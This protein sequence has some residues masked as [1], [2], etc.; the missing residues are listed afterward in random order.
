MYRSKTLVV[1]WKDILL[2]YRTKEILSGTAVFSLLVIVVFNFAFDLRVESIVAVAP[3]ALW[4][5][6]AFAGVL[7]LGRSFVLERD[8]G[9]WE[10]LL[11][12]PIDRGSI[13]LGKLIGNVVFIGMVELVTLPIAT[14]LFNVPLVTPAIGLPIL[15]GTVGFAAVGT[16][17]AAIAANTRAREVLLPVLL[18]PIAVPVLIAS[19]KATGDALAGQVGGS[20][21]LGLL[22]VFDALYLALGSV[23]FEFAVED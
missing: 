19:V 17:F 12:C 2:E 5:A 10:G 14:A 18:F 11:L 3:G 21:W 4:V 23:V 20:P 22:L 6:F 13:Y 15:L 8:R 7:G 1:L 9:S 16:L